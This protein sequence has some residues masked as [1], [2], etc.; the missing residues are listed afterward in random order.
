MIIFY[1][2]TFIKSFQRLHIQQQISNRTLNTIRHRAR[3]IFMKNKSA[4]DKKNTVQIQ[5][6]TLNEITS[7]NNEGTRRNKRFIA[8]VNEVIALHF[9]MQNLMLT[10]YLQK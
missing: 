6:N 5:Q 3:S 2:S 10:N 9:L 8:I 1:L 4:I 7:L